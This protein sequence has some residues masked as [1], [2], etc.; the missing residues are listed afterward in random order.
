MVEGR[1]RRHF[2]ITDVKRAIKTARDAGI[3]V[4]MVEIVTSDGTIIRIGG[5]RDDGKSNEGKKALNEWLEK[6]ARKSQGN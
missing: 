6:H 4:E 3:D 1:R 2:K 5:H